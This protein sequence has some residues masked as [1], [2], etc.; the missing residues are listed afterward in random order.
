MDNEDSKAS[1]DSSKNYIVSEAQLLAEKARRDKSERFKTHGEPIEL[2]GKALAFEVRGKHA[3]VGEST[4]VVRRLDLE[5]GKTLQLYKGHMGPVTTIAFYDV[6]GS[7]GQKLLIS[8][9]WDQSIKIWDS[10]TKQLLSTTKDAHSDFVKSLLVIPS[11]KLLVSGGSDKI[12]R[13][14][15]L[16]SA[17][18]SEPLK[19]AGSI[20]SHTRPIECLAGYATSDSSAILYTAD[21]MGVLRVWTLQKEA[22]VKPPRW[23]CSPKGELTHHRTRINDMALGQNLVWTASSDDTAQIHSA[24]ESEAS[25]VKLPKPLEHPT[26]VKAIL[27]LPLTEL[28]ESYLLTVAGDYLRVYDIS[29]LHEPELVSTTDVHWHDATAIRLWFR[30]TK[31]ESGEVTLVEPYIVTTSLDHSIRKWRLA[32][33]LMPIPPPSLKPEPPKQ[34]EPK[35]S[36]GMTE[37]EERELAELMGDD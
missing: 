26:A 8:G 32:D 15:D 25:D 29:T 9:S 2:P 7:E 30:H 34:E 17:G 31:S 37:E 12:T 21:T 24:I 22:G 23:K 36:T 1:V 33:L 11:L 5:T 19:S 13:L 10:K 20:S 18:T 27:P 4:A 14:W 6:E 16:S 3:W 28:G 35:T